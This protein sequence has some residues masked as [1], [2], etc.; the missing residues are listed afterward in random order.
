MCERDL[1]GKTCLRAWGRSAVRCDGLQRER[2]ELSSV[3]FEG[4]KLESWLKEETLAP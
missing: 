2:R 4:G 1:L 3:K